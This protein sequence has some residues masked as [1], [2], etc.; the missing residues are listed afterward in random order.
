MITECNI[1]TENHSD[2]YTVWG[3]RES[4]HIQKQQETTITLELKCFDMEFQTWLY[5][6][7]LKPKINKKL[8]K[9][10]TI[11]E[12]LFAVRNKINK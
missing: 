9:D 10:C 12:L 5:G 1:Q 7:K 2:V 11:S 8:V 6:E 3:K 4:A